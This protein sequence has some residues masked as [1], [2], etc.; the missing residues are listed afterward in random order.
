MYPILYVGCICKGCVCVRECVKT[1]GKV[2][3]KKFSQVTREK[4]SHKVMHMSSTWLECKELGQ[5]GDS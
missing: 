5:D 3:S 1:Q 2:K 4:L